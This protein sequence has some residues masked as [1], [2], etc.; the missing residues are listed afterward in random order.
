MSPL[1]CRLVSTVP[2]DTPLNRVLE[3]HREQ[4]LRCQ[5]DVARS[6]GMSRDLSSIGH[7]TL[8]APEGLATTVM[9]RL[10]AQDGSDPRRPL[11][12]RLAVRYSVAGVIGVATIAALLARAITRRKN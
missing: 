9:S 4:C 8:V 12:V 7:E 10:P 11:V 3:A 5:A 1:I 6:T 2:P